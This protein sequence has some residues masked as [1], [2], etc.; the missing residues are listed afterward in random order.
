VGRAALHDSGTLLRT[1]SPD[2]PEGDGWI[3]AVVDNLVTN[4]SDLVVLDAQRLEEGPVGRAM[5]PFRLKSGL[6]GNW[7]DD[8]KYASFA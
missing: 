7:C 1:R 6:H 2:S 5:L 4:Y 3:I 8:R